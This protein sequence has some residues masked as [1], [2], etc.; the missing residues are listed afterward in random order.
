[1]PNLQGKVAL[2]T[3]AS[4]G[5]GEATALHFASLGCCLALTARDDAKLKRVAE[6]CCK[7]GLPLENVLV[8]PGDV[9]VGSDVADVVEKTVKH[10]GKIDILRLEKEIGPAHALGRIG[11]PEE[12]ARCV[13]FLASEDAAFITGA[14]VS[15]DGGLPLLSSISGAPEES[16][17]K[18]N[19]DKRHNT[20][21]ASIN[22]DI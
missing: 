17:L 9:T 11:T 2:I 14:T 15:V 10:F 21:S 22:N 8:V 19:V 6:A 5:I 4:R 12:V 7:E 1:M 16:S 18:K 13:A 20:R 3:G